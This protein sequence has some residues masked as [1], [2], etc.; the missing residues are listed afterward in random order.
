M[1]VFRKVDFPHAST[2]KELENPI[3]TDMVAHRE[4]RHRDW[5]ERNCYLYVKS[6]Y[7]SRF[8]KQNLYHPVSAS[9]LSNQPPDLSS[10]IPIGDPYRLIVF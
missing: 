10:K 4:F 7:F 3:R 9:H 1:P 8:Q 5:M 6:D 2:T